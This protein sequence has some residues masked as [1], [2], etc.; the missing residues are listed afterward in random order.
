VQ[1]F[2]EMPLTIQVLI[3]TDI[4]RD[5]KAS[6]AARDIVLAHLAANL[7]VVLRM[8]TMGVVLPVKILRF[9]IVLSTMHLNNAIVILPTTIFPIDLGLEVAIGIDLGFGSKD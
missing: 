5:G 2:Y 1:R 6:V 3:G 4:V 9:P 7:P 8:V